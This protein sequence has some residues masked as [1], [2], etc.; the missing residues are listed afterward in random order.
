LHRRPFST[1]NELKKYP[2]GCF[3]LENPPAEGSKE[4]RCFVCHATAEEVNLGYTP[5]CNVPVC[6]NEFEYEFCSYS[7]D[8]RSHMHYTVCHEH[9]EEGHGGPDWR[10][11]DR[12]N[13]KSLQR[14]FKTT[15]NFNVTPTLEKYIP[16]GSFIT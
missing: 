12:C 2:I 8:L 5:C 3:P 9:S 14:P 4:M 6:D 11:C 16:Q 15:N 13:L 10:E 7:R 1:P